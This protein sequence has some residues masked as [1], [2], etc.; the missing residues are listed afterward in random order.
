M[1]YAYQVLFCII[2]GITMF[3][4]DTTV[5]NVALAKL[6][7]VFG[8]DVATVQWTITAYALASGMITP[9]AD[10]FVARRGMKRVWIAGLAGFTL[11]SMLGG[12]APGYPIL[13]IARI[14][15]GLSGGLL[16][17]IGI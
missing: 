12:I 16:L 4:I 5:V 14:L 9:M 11:A 3:L 2:A 1:S 7:A 6:E 10:Y 8:V 15:Q 17:P 13:V